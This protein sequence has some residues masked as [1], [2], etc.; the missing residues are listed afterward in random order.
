MFRGSCPEL[1]MPPSR[2]SLAVTV[3]CTTEDRVYRREN[4]S[5]LEPH[6]V[7]AFSKSEIAAP[8]GELFHVKIEPGIRLPRPKARFSIEVQVG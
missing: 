1:C 6:V 2:A 8:V 4:S 3:R 7:T 5:D